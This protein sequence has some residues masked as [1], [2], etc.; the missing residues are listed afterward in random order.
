MVVDEVGLGVS[1]M[2]C[3]TKG[4]D[5]TLGGRVVVVVDV[6]VVV[7]LVVLVVLV[8]VVVVDVVVVVVVVSTTPS[9][10]L[11]ASALVLAAELVS[12][13]LPVPFMK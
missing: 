12:W 8:V 13:T 6:V 4:L 11:I 5:P 3:M 2:I 1:G 10:N 7:V 9:T